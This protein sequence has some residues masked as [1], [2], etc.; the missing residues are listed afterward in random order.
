M[1][2]TLRRSLM[3]PYQRGVP[4]QYAVHYHPWPTR[5]HGPL[6]QR[7]VFMFP[8]MSSPQNV[9]KPGDFYP[10]ELTEAQMSIQGLG[11]AEHMTGREAILYDTGRGVFKP[12]G[13]GGGIFDGNLSGIT[14]LSG[15]GVLGEPPDK[16]A[17]PL[18]TPRRRRRRMLEGLGVIPSTCWD[19]PGFKD[20]ANRKFVE[21]QKQC[22]EGSILHPFE[23]TTECEKRVHAEL[24]E[25]QCVPVLCPAGAP[26]TAAAPAGTYPWKAYSPDTLA[27]QKSTNVALKSAGYCPISEDGKLGGGT[28]GALKTL[29]KAT[30]PTC[31]AFTTPPKPP[32]AAAA[33]RAGFITTSL[34]PVTA[35]A[36]TPTT[37]QFGTAPDWKKYA[38]FAAGAVI[39][40]GGAYLLLRRKKGA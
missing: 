4:T 1:T 21:A 7:P 23:S 16:M 38:A 11:A 28:C 31:Q 33:P 20:C 14:A 36:V 35:A 8:W 32:C 22:A 39:V 27:L 29:G 40:A 5:F 18:T 2:M 25:S 15:L 37:L 17:R 10:G 12:G 26:V 19:T 9:F 6:Y 30:P 13:Y 34:A 24:T 3:G